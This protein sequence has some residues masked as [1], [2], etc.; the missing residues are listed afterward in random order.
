M[1]KTF[2]FRGSEEF[3]KAIFPCLEAAGYTRVE[4]VEDAKVVITHCLSQSSLEDTYFEEDGILQAASAG[5]LLIDLSSSTPSFARELNAIAIVSDLAA[6]EAPL[7][8]QDL[9]KD[10]AFS[11][12]ENLACF[13]GGDEDVIKQTIPLLE[14][15]IGNVQLLGG[16]GSAQLARAAYTLQTTAQVV[17]AIESDALCRAVMDSPV[18]PVSF[19]G[20]GVGASTAVVEQVLSA[21]SSGSFSGVYTVEMFMGELSAALTTADDVD[22]ILPQA[23]SCLHLLELLA[24]IGGAK[25]AVSA[26]SL[27][28]GD[29]QSCAQEGLD[30]TRAEKAYGTPVDGLDL[31]ELGDFEDEDD[32]DTYPGYSDYPGYSAN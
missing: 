29:E 15:F 22:L 23:E 14:L 9:M 17:S 27:V 24:V 5:T 8:V 16:A 11:D 7:I 32:C 30:W 26:L 21:I 10:D 4:L 19:K 20:Q 28:Y 31:D 2:V 3:Q 13:V 1:D 25:K 6:V 18:A 12:K